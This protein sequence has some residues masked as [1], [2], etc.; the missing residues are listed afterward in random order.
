[1]QMYRRHVCHQP[2]KINGFPNAAGALGQEVRLT[3]RVGAPVGGATEW[4]HQHLGGAGKWRCR[5]ARLVREG[6]RWCAPKQAAETNSRGDARAAERART[7]G[8][9]SPDWKAGNCPDPLTVNAQRLWLR[10]GEQV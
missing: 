10:L 3:H 4:A 1:M 9:K 5:G 2:G 6:A 8:T 7:G